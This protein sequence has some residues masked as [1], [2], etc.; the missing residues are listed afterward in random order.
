MRVIRSSD[1]AIIDVRFK[2]VA[3]A[4]PEA[5]RRKVGSIFIP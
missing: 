4:L 2:Y 1:V 5:K 3:F